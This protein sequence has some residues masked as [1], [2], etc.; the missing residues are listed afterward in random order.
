[1]F[2]R[3]RLPIALVIVQIIDV[4][5]HAASNQLETLRVASNLVILAWAALI[6]FGRVKTN[7]RL[8]HFAALGIY[9]VMNLIF[10]A[11]EGVVN[12]TNGQVR[13]MLFVLVGLTVIL[14]GVV[15]FARPRE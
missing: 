13:V 4:V 6:V 2:V 8:V 1:M 12:P 15:A 5:V 11:T 10:V 3:F 14:S 7:A 9:L